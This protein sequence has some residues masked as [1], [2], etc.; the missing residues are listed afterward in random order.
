MTTKEVESE[1]LR[2]KSGGFWN[3]LK[4]PDKKI[5]EVNYIFYGSVLLAS[6]IKLGFKVSEDDKAIQTYEEIKMN[7]RT[8]FLIQIFL[9][10]QKIADMNSKIL[11]SCWQMSKSCWQIYFLLLAHYQP[12]LY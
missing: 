6:I 1:F 5:I 4:W 10:W 3:F 12:I 9:R 11:S 8:A 2:Y 7:N